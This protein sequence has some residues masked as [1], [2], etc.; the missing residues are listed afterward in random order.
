MAIVKIYRAAYVKGTEDGAVI[1]FSGWVRVEG[2][3]ETEA[4]MATGI[5]EGQQII[6]WEEKILDTEPVQHESSVYRVRW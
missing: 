2:M 5:F 3:D 1:H 6:G 4:L